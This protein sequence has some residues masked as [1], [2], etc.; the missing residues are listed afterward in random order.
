MA[1]VAAGEG[2]Q[3]SAR[4]SPLGRLQACTAPLLHQPQTGFGSAGSLVEP[5]SAMDNTAR[6][7]RG[8][9]GVGHS[10]STGPAGPHRSPGLGKRIDQWTQADEHRAHGPGA[11]QRARPTRAGMAAQAS[12]LF[13]AGPSRGTGRCNP[14]LQCA[15]KVAYAPLTSMVPGSR[16]GSAAVN[17][18]GRTA[19]EVLRPVRLR[20]GLCVRA[21]ARTAC[22]QVCW[23]GPHRVNSACARG[24]VIAVWPGWT[25]LNRWPTPCFRP[26]RERAVVVHGRWRLSTRPSLAGPSQPTWLRP[27]WSSAASSAWGVAELSM[28]QRRWVG[29]AG[30]VGGPS[31]RRLAMSSS[32]FRLPATCGARLGGSLAQNG[33]WWH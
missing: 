4:P 16:P 17:R 8:E 15:R 11:G 30:S 31:R 27:W 3:R 18:M 12:Q 22:S 9:Q 19:F 26:R 33:R 13:K 5:P 10:V 28:A 21:L 25:C 14:H 2:L 23:R 7:T 32:R 6:S 24:Q 20:A 1:S 29:A